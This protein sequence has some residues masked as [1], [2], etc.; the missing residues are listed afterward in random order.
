MLKHKNISVSTPEVCRKHIINS[1]LLVI[2]SPRSKN[3]ILEWINKDSAIL[4]NKKVEV[5]GVTKSNVDLNSTQ[6][7]PRL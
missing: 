4:D 2:F 7:L 6:L 5:I 3:N 1:D